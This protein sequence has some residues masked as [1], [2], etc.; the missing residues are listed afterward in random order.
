MMIRAS[1]RDDNNVTLIRLPKNFCRVLFNFQ[2][3]LSYFEHTY[4]FRA[5]YVRGIWFVRFY[6]RIQLSRK[7]GVVRQRRAINAYK[8]REKKKRMNASTFTGYEDFGSTDGM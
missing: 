6:I 3:R 2:S 7:Y 1:F 5:E 8:F 4:I